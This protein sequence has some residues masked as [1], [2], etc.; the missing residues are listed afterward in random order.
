MVLSDIH[1]AQRDHASMLGKA[2]LRQFA[3]G[4][5]GGWLGP[6]SSTQCAGLLW[7]TC[8]SQASSWEMG[9]EQKQI[10][11]LLLCFASKPQGLLETIPSH[12]L[13][14][15]LEAPSTQLGQPKLPCSR[16][17]LQD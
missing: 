17:K 9:G 16:K 13:A 7:G 10:L 3:A 14:L 1:E 11:V 5:L 12:F 15:S 8:L 2:T 6:L 4:V